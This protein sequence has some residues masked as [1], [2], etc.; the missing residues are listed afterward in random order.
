M[1]R[2]ELEAPAEGKYEQLELGFDPDHAIAWTYMKPKGAPCFNRGLLGELR[3]HDR[4]FEASG[5]RVFAGGELRQ[6]RYHVLAS[7]IPGVYNLGGDLD[8]FVEL[9]RSGDRDRL[10]TYAKLC[11]D[12][13]SARIDNYHL[14]VMTLSLVQGDALGGGFETA[15]ASNVIVAERQSRLGLPEILFNLFPGMGAYSLLGRRVGVRQAEEMILSGRIYAAAELHALGVVDVLAEDGEGR[16]AVQEFVRQAD[17]KHNGMLAVFEARRRFC[18]VPYGEL[19]DITR[20]WVEAAL[21]V[22]ERDLKV[23]ARI[24]RA[25]RHQLERA[26]RAARPAPAEAVVY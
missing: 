24:A 5:G 17:R 4:A 12:D 3:D 13:M 16:T 25:Q 26:G 20:I 6:A 15:L 10:F 11:I 18:P 19:I 22:T 14:P 1:N 7:A 2:T 8:L 9:I 21:R 23:M